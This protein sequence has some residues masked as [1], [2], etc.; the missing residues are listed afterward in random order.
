MGNQQTFWPT[1]YDADWVFVCFVGSPKVNCLKAL[2][3]IIYFI[4][5]DEFRFHIKEQ[6]LGNPLSNV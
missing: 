2:A 3:L 4:S 1:Q 6:I 5:E